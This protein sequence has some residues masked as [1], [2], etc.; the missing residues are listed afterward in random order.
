LELKRVSIPGEIPL[1]RALMR[2]RGI[3]N[4]LSVVATQVLSN[5]LKLSKDVKVGELTDDQ[6]AQI[7]AILSETS[8]SGK[9][10]PFCG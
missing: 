10:L 5:E 1:N 4:T 6:I 9:K 7:D 3:G 2:I 8:P